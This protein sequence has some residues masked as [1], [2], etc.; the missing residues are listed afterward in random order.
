MDPKANA[1]RR[2]K[3]KSAQ[4]DDHAISIKEKDDDD[5]GDAAPSLKAKDDG[6]M[7]PAHMDLMSKLTSQMSHPGR[8]AI[9]LEEKANSG[10]K[11]KMASILKHRK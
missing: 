6:E 8:G 7:G 2:M 4:Q 1:I 11:E 9:S 3:L 5:R 10:M